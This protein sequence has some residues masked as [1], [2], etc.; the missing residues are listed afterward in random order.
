MGFYIVEM[1]L[2]RQCRGAMSKPMGVECLDEFNMSGVVYHR[3]SS[4]GVLEL[5]R[6]T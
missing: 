2:R 5:S 6:V 4:N 3:L 1:L